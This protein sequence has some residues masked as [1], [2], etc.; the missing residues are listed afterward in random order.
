MTLGGL[1]NCLAAAEGME[2]ARHLALGFLIT[3]YDADFLL[4]RFMGETGRK[5]CRLFQT[6]WSS[7]IIAELERKPNRERI[8]TMSGFSHRGAAEE[9]FNDYLLLLKKTGARLIRFFIEQAA[10]NF[11][12]QVLR[13]ARKLGITPS[14]WPDRPAAAGDVLASMSEGISTCW[15]V[16]GIRI[17]YLLVHAARQT[18]KR[19]T[20]R[21]KQDGKRHET[22]GTC[23]EDSRTR[24]AMINRQNREI[25]HESNA[26]DW[27]DDDP[28]GDDDGW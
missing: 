22:E 9:A 7:L 14:Q 18:R 12:K 15:P 20:K 5:K 10:V 21:W 13:T 1:V 25:Y 2:C 4:G 17:D 6:R 3:A 8:L 16:A 26:D 11:S 24:Q 27:I 28:L 19:A 23:G